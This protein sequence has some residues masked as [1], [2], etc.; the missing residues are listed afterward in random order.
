MDQKDLILYNQGEPQGEW[1]VDR[2]LLVEAAKEVFP[3]ADETHYRSQKAVTHM[4]WIINHPNFPKY[5]QAIQNL[6]D[7][8]KDN[9]QFVK[10]YN[11]SKDPNKMFD[12]SI[13]H[14]SRY[15]SYLKLQA[16]KMTATYQIAQDRLEYPVFTL[17]GVAK[18]YTEKAKIIF[19]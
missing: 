15:P 17:L 9:A 8:E 19:M 1:R 6:E 16:D 13:L 12:G 11:D 5:I 2:D 18:V 14:D 4:E 10:K 7:F 3:N